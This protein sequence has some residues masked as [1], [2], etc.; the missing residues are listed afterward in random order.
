MFK[1]VWK[2]LLRT[3]RRPY[4]AR[5][6]QVM[7]QMRSIR[8]FFFFWLVLTE[9]PHRKKREMTRDNG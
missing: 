9:K 5:S 1:T 4:Y 2:C 3:S 7:S 6:V 8:C